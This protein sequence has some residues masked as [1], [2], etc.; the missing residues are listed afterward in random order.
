MSRSICIYALVASGL[1]ISSMIGSA[2]AFSRSSAKSFRLSEIDHFA[3][4]YVLIRDQSEDLKQAINRATDA[5][6]FLRR[7]TA[8]RQL[9]EKVVL[10][11]AFAMGRSGEIFRTSLAGK[12]ILSLP[13]SGATVLW[14]A[15]FGETVQARLQPGPELLEIFEMKRA[16]CEHLFRL[17]P[18]SRVLTVDVRITSD[19]LPK[20][21]E[22]QLIYRRA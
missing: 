18:D 21:V 14:K 11:P 5:M 20:P 4:R 3:G 22:Y 7:L 13:L 9:R 1:L 6:N 16:H 12:T 15:P 17:S 10:Y 2:S 8:R 19:E